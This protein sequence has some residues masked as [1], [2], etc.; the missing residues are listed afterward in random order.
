MKAILQYGPNDLRYEDIPYPKCEPGGMIMKVMAV[1]LCGSDIRNLTTDSLPGHYPQIWGH[2]HA[3]IIKEI[4]P[5]YKGDLK[6]GDRVIYWATIS[7]GKC[8]E[9]RNGNTNFCLNNN[10]FTF[11]QGGF[12][13]YMPIPEV[14]IERNG[15]VKL[16]D[17][18]DFEAMG[19]IE[20]LLS[21]NGCQ[22]NLKIDY[23]DTLVICGA[24]TLGCLH[25]KVA[26]I[27][28]CKKVI[29]TEVTAAR[30]EGVEKFGVDVKIDASKVDQIEAV[31]KET[32]GRG[33]TKV[34]CANPS[35]ISQQQAI[36]MVRPSGVISYFGGV[37]KGSL[38]EIDSN[39]VHYKGLTIIGQYGGDELARNMA[40]EL[41]F[42]KRLKWEDFIT[43]RMPLSKISEAIARCKAGKEVK[44]ALLPWMDENGNEIAE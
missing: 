15:V 17:D 10:E 23:R 31:L 12:A 9:C 8:E 28:G 39:I 3:G 14:V 42:S 24:G 2:E 41:V 34:I 40:M 35:T 25:A 6:V 44:V 20:P 22:Q 18:I 26:K 21:V 36:K 5:E 27:R 38:T 29:M 1:G 13:Q 32:D 33:A 43:N 37:P 30:L 7:C 19:V 16:P 11:R 4:G